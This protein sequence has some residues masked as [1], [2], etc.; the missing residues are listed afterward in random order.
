LET[1]NVKVD[2]PFDFIEISKCP[3]IEMNDIG[4]FAIYVRAS[5]KSKSNGVE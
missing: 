5:G 4:D 1:E 3:P 2:R